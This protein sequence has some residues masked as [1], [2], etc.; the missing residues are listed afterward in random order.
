MGLLSI[1]EFARLARLS[2]KALRLYDEL[3][4]LSPASVD[5]GSG[6]RWYDARQLEQAWLVAS[7]RQLGTPLAQISVILRLAPEAAAGQ[8]RLCWAAAEAEHADRRE[9]AARKGRC[10]RRRRNP[11]S[12]IDMIADQ[13][14]GTEPPRVTVRARIPRVARR[15]LSAMT[16]KIPASFHCESM[17]DQS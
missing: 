2:P 7:L 11:A 4:L 8:V 17:D 15:A 3:G 13:A 5:P 12:V 6:Y 14:G 10:H 16:G 1:G 9:L